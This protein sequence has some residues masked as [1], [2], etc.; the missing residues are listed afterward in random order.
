MTALLAS[1]RICGEDFSVF[2]F[3]DFHPSKVQLFP[4]D[5]EKLF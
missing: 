2:Q 5:P 4:I 1:K 3:F